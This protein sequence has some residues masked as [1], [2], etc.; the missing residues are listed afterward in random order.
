MPEDGGR[1]AQEREAARL[2]RERRRA[3]AGA[4]EGAGPDGD[5][6][7]EWE[8]EDEVASGTRRVGWRE[9]NDTTAAVRSE[10]AP[11]GAKG[12]PRTAASAGHSS[13]VCSPCS[14]CWSRGP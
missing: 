7:G 1:T 6:A 2:E 13:A 12:R 4:P 10:R 9:R 14:P 8:H 5:G 11:A 3:E